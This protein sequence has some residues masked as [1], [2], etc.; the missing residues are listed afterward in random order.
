MMVL[1]ISDLVLY[2]FVKA[3]SE[4]YRA[5][6]LLVGCLAAIKSLAS[7]EARTRFTCFPG[8]MLACYTIGAD[9]P[10]TSVWN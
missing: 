4:H 5:Y 2:M 9:Q 7:G 3:W 8:R 10:Q 6:K 1:N